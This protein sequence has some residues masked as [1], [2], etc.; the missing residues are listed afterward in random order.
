MQCPN[1]YTDTSPT[2][3]RCA[4]CN[5]P[6]F[7]Q[8]PPETPT[9]DPAAYSAPVYDSPARDTPPYDPGAYETAR[10]PGRDVSGYGGGGSGQYW[11]PAQEW[12][13]DAEPAQS[14]S[15]ESEPW[16]TPPRRRRSRRPLFVATIVG[17]T[18]GCLVAAGVLLWPD[19]DRSATGPS[20]PAASSEASSAGSRA[21]ATAVNELLDE[22]AASRSELSPA[23][24]DAMRCDGVDVAIDQ[25]ER[26]RKQRE[27]QLAKVRE[28]QVDTL[29]SG[30]EMRRT[31][32]QA[33][34]FSLDADKAF[35]DWATDHQGCTAAKTPLD[36]QF[37]RGVALSA[38]Q[39]TPAKK[40]FADLW[41]PVAQ[42]HGLPARSAD[43]F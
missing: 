43:K 30:A 2:M 15:A 17:V 8:T 20:S 40:A 6:L 24:A 1:C 5:T 26:V 34:V 38:D 31:L 18:L 28:L 27:D 4:R 7:P 10:E 25:L 16:R 41:N 32:N 36:S 22:M 19:G 12:Q 23:M 33:A 9:R 29:P 42:K 21:Q 35:L 39:A 11:E 37:K 3:V 14:F 13:P